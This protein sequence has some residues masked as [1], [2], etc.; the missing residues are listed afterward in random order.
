KGRLAKDGRQQAD[1]RWMP[2]GVEMLPMNRRNDRAT[3]RITS[4]DS[5]LRAVK[6]QRSTRRNERP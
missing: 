2:A 3:Q 6:K 5:H 4:T 1:R